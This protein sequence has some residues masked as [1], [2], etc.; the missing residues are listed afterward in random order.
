MKTFGIIG[1]GRFGKLWA[2]SLKPL[3]NVRIADKKTS[4]AALAKTLEVDFLF[5]L[6]PISE[7]KNLCKKIAPQLQPNTV[8]IDACSVKVLPVQTMKKLLLRKQ[9]IIATHPLFGPDSVKKFGLAR[10]KIVVSNIRATGAQLAAFEK[11]L[12]KLKLKIIHTTPRHHDQQMAKSQ[13]L[14]HFLGRGLAAL[15]LQKQAISTPDYQALLHMNDM[16]NNDTRQLFF[17]MQNCNPYTK[18]IRHKFLKSLTKLDHEID[19]RKSRR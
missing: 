17:D 4:P 12:H 16:V 15:K 10:Q 18:K 5:L 7:I 13:A 14:I 3:G 1:F 19:R 8:V 2:N 9:P 11:I 6:V